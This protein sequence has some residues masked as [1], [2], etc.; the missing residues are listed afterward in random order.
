[1]T[2]KIPM[3]LLVLL[4][5]QL[6]INA[7][8]RGG[9]SEDERIRQE[10]QRLRPTTGEALMMSVGLGEIVRAARA[11]AASAD[12]QIGDRI[13]DAILR[14]DDVLL[15]QLVDSEILSNVNQRF[16]YLISSQC[17][18]LMVAAREG[19][20]DLVH[21]LIAAGAN[22]D[23]QSQDGK[24][25]LMFAAECRNA[26]AVEIIGVLCRHGA[27]VNAMAY[28]VV[29]EGRGYGQG[30]TVLAHAI[31]AG[32]LANVEALLAHHANPG[33]ARPAPDKRSALELTVQVVRDAD[34]ERKRMRMLHGGH[35]DATYASPI[36]YD[37]QVKMLQV[38][39][40][41]GADVN[42]T[43]AM[44]Y[45]EDLSGWGEPVE[46]EGMPRMGT[47]LVLA[48]KYGY[49]AMVEVILNART[50]DFSIEDQGNVAANVATIKG[51]GEIAEIIRARLPK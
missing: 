7:M 4:T 47:V 26:A 5:L 41:H 29:M 43:F 37:N 20:V 49:K 38:L 10:E 18:M 11:R 19:K 25:A 16:D 2:K 8:E 30:W 22:P 40:D 14:R 6:S 33:L 51:Y 44:P 36:K 1:M 28:A 9:P 39:I 27:N 45:E 17:T 13:S 48:A 12:R 3:L 21:Y 34:I 15:N 32:S 24:T 50:L 23:L 42:E 35:T 46:E 31:Q